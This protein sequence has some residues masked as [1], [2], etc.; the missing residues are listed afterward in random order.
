M[1]DYHNDDADWSSDRHSM[2]KHIRFL[3]QGSLEKFITHGLL[4]LCPHYSH[5]YFIET[6]AFT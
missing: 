6:N 2:F 5:L 3:S 1:A 4:F